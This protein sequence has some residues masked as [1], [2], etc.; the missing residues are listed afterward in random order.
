M[1]KTRIFLTKLLAVAALAGFG[2]AHS[3][4]ADSVSFATT[5]YYAGP[6][7]DGTDN[8]FGVVN[9]IGN[10]I[11][12]LA[13][14][15][16]GAAGTL[17][18]NTSGNPGVSLT[19][20]D[21]T[22]ML[23]GATNTIVTGTT[24]NTG[25]YTFNSAS[26]YFGVATVG[27]TTGFGCTAGQTCNT[28]SNP[29]DVTTINVAASGVI[30]VSSSSLELVAKQTTPAGVPEIDPTSA[31]SPLALLAGAAMMIRGRRK[32]IAMAS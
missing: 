2:I 30:T 13:I 12:T 26:D 1:G 17:T 6:S 4:K 23:Y 28:G 16:A 21:F 11:S 25:V 19:G 27:G 3:A 10:A 7:S 5:V 9:P 29:L 31:M 24:L 8:P 22:V 18:F 15:P 20:T 32:K 14:T